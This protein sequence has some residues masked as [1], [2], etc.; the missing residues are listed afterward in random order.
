MKGGIPGDLI[1]AVFPLCHGWVLSYPCDVYETGRGLGVVL[2]GMPDW[3]GKNALR[4]KNTRTWQRV[5][6]AKG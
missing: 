3:N 6:N 5:T 1:P 4:F 2:R